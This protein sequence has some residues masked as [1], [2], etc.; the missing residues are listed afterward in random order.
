MHN[1]TEMRLSFFLLSQLVSRG[2]RS[3]VERRADQMF[4]VGKGSKASTLLLPLLLPLPL[5]L[6]GTYC[7]YRW[8]D[9]SMRIRN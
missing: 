9:D 4:E 7:M 1:T 2:C 6:L 3:L 5:L 8:L